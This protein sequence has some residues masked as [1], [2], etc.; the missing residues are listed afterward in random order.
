MNASGRRLSKV[1]ADR[2]EFGWEFGCGD[3]VVSG[4]G[5]AASRDARAAVSETGR[6]FCRAL[7]DSGALFSERGTVFG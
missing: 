7:G 4:R 5:H 2:G 3:A 1:L 6:A